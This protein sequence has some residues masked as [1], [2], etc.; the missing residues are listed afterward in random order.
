LVL[1]LFF[2][3]VGKRFVNQHHGDIILNGIEQATGFADQTIPLS[4][5]ENISLTFGTG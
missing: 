2:S 4:I 3:F 1:F 5:Q